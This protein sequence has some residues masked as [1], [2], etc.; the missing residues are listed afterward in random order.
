MSV[1]MHS[2]LA[3]NEVEGNYKK[4]FKNRVKYNIA[5]QATANKRENLRNV[6]AA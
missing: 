4:D 1:Y 6:T 3:P 5:F 2:V